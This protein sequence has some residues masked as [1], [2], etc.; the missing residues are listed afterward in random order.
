MRI[1]R[2]PTLTEAECLG[3]VSAF[4]DSL[5][6]TIEGMLTFL[7]RLQGQPK[8]AA[9][10]FEMQL[11][12]QRYGIMLILERWG[13]WVHH[14]GPHLHSMRDASVLHDAPLRIRMS[15]DLMIRTNRLIDAAEQ[16][17]PD[18]LH[19]AEQSAQTIM[20][21]FSHERAAAEQMLNLGP[22]QPAEFGEARRIFLTDLAAR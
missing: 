21:T 6:S 20:R 7:R 2:Y 19:A 22:L 17:T 8:G 18:L 12:S 14:F 9:F 1:L 5:S 3:C 11:D 13:E 4:V 15:E 16:Y 10:A